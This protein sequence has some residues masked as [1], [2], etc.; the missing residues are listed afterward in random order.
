M[1]AAPRPA[2]ANGRIAL[3]VPSLAGGGA[4]RTMVHLARGFAARGYDVDLVL[5]AAKGP[6]LADVPRDVRIV[7]LHAGGVAAALPGL[8]RYLRRERPR[9]LLST[10]NRPNIAAIVA[11]RLARVA[12]RAVVRQSNTFSET[13]R[14]ATRG[15]PRV[16]SVLVRHVYPW[17]DDIVAVSDGVAHDLTLAAGLPRERIRVIPNPVVSPE[18]FDLARQPVE[19]P[20]FAPG[21]PPVVLGVGRL[22]KQKDYTSLIAAF[23]R[24]LSRRP[25][26]LVILGEGSERQRLEAYVAGLGLQESVSLPGFAQNPFAYMARAAVFVLSSTFE[27]LPGALIQALACGTP[28]VA[29]DCPSGPREILRGGQFGRLVPVGDVA[30]LATAIAGA[31][32]EPKTP[33]PPEAWAAFTHDAAVDR[34]LRVLRGAA[35]A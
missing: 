31:L 9:G 34:Y 1:T 19:H 18:L 5:V 10:L 11:T 12:T 17:A 20:W 35:D 32:S 33:A 23:A 15:M 24:V 4:E 6:Y 22:A 7:D 16:L 8:V 25:A 27:G 14:R 29:T 30:A 21:Q 13:S 28:V 3:F 26:R 2:P